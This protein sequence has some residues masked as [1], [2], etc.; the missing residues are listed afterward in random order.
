M[1]IAPHNPNGPVATTANI[2]LAATIPNFIILEYVQP[3]SAHTRVIK[4]PLKL[5][6]GHFELPEAPSLGID[7]D[8]EVIKAYPFSSWPLIG[9]KEF[10]K[11]LNILDIS[12]GGNPSPVWSKLFL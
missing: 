9:T 1:G 7:L 11:F 10:G 6:G 4:E 5:S 2:Q 3:A 12:I 8:E